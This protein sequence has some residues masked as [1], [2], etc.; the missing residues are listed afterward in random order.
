[1]EL[2]LY[3]YVFSSLFGAKTLSKTLSSSQGPVTRNG[4]EV[5]MASTVHWSRERQGK[6]GQQIT[7]VSN[8]EQDDELQKGVADADVTSTKKNEKSIVGF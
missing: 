5:H 8:T 6:N 2:L 1:L 3:N 7:Q 4:N